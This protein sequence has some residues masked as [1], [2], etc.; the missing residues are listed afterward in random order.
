[1]SDKSNIV[2]QANSR[3]GPCELLG[4][5]VAEHTAGLVYRCQSGLKAHIPKRLAH[6]EPCRSCLDHHHSRFPGLAFKCGSKQNSCSQTHCDCSWW[7]AVLCGCSPT[8]S[9]TG[10]AC[11]WSRRRQ[12]RRCKWHTSAKATRK[13]A[14]AAFAKSWRRS[15]AI[16]GYESPSSGKTAPDEAAS[17]FRRTPPRQKGD[18]PGRGPRTLGGF[19]GGTTE[20]PRNVRFGLA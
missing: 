8:V 19:V 10:E 18:E 12:D 7:K 11:R 15:W 13:A 4:P 2:R 6:L 3:G 20:S 16:V 14:M 1:M 17:P 9:A 5:L